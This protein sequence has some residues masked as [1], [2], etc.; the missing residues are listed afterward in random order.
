MREA[1]ALIGRHLRAML[2][3]RSSR[4]ALAAS[5]IVF[6]GV[7]L[8]TRGDGVSRSTLTLAS[9]LVVGVIAFGT[10]AWSGALLPAD[11]AEGREVW[12][13]SLAP[14]GAA[15]RVAAAVAGMLLA[16]G[17]AV[18][19]SGL[20]AFVLP[21]VL[22]DASVRSAREIELPGRVRVGRARRSVPQAT[23]DLGGPVAPGAAIELVV[24]P[25]YFG[26]GQEAPE[27]ATRQPLRLAWTIRGD[28]ES[29]EGSAV[30]PRGAPVTIALPAGARTFTLSS[31]GPRVDVV[32]KE[33][34][35]LGEDRPL[36]LTLLLGG[37][38]L[39]LTAATV[40]PL[41]VAIS[42]WTSAPTA[43]TA[44]FVVAIAGGLRFLL[45]DLALPDAGR[46]HELGLA[47]VGA[48]S[49]L[50]PDL[51]PLGVLAEPA[52][53]RALDG[54]GVGTLL[55]LFAYGAVGLLVVAW[56]TRAEPARGRSS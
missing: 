34:R 27:D 35:V 53:G 18:V 15:R 36:L 42:R 28:A 8:A 54:V 12:L 30:L 9:F 56:P 32:V 24:S 25:L 19:G 23:L 44:S 31:E 39:G 14:S 11:R 50:A 13:A 16:V 2:R 45:P 4:I 6:L 26:V 40:A 22:P 10:A 52:A 38:V 7:L 3:G 33:A 37:L 1:G 29:V 41:A 49:R 48:V 20:L 46:L 5:L 51:G 21:V 43:T 47:I 17:V 55:P